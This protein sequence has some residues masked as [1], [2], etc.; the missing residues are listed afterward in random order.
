MTP[1]ATDAAIHSRTAGV[2]SSGFTGGV[3]TSGLPSTPTFH[4][5]LDAAAVPGGASVGSAGGAR[6]LD[7]G[8]D[9]DI[10]GLTDCREFFGLRRGGFH[11]A[12]DVAD[13]DGDGVLDGLDNCPCA[14]NASQADVD[15][16]GVG[17]L[18]ESSFAADC[19]GAAYNTLAGIAPNCQ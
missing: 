17:D 14:A 4:N 12:L 1:S 11:T 16:D 6:S 19:R 8:N 10:D 9:S 5:P 13:T 18:C 15:G 7:N 3:G 2:S